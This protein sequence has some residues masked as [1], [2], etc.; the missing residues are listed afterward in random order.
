MSDEG[1]FFGGFAIGAVS[2]LVLALAI[3]SCREAGRNRDSEILRVE[4][5]NINNGA[6]REMIE[7]MVKT[8]FPSN[9]WENV[10]YDCTKNRVEVKFSNP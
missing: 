2:V 9:K 6:S 10:E 1:C 3:L 8:Q 4:Y 5:K 7:D